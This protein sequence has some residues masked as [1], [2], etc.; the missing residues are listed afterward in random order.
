MKNKRNKNTF[1]NRLLFTIHC[2]RFARKMT[3]FKLREFYWDLFRNQHK[4]RFPHWKIVIA[5]KASI[6]EL[7][8]RND[9]SK[10][11][12]TRVCNSR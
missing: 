4:S 1:F 10:L 2:K 12:K 11:A 5:L 8:K 6:N 3:D 9:K 7:S